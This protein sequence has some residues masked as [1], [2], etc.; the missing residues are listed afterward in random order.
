[1]SDA[2]QVRFWGVRGSIPCPGLS[3]ATYGGN[4]ACVE[5]R[6]GDTVL[7]LDAGTGLRPLGQALRAEG[8]TTLHLLLSHVHLDHV[9]GLP[10]FEPAYDPHTRLVIRA[11]NLLPEARL[12]QTLERLLSV[13]FFP[14]SPDVFR[15]AVDCVDFRAGEAFQL[16]G[17]VHVT[18]APLNHP[19]RAT[20][21]RI[22][23]QG[24]S[25][26]Y[27]TDTE[28]PASGLDA[29]ILNLI[30]GT[31]L[32]IYDSTYN[33]ATYPAHKGWGHSTWEAG[34]ALAQAGEVRGFALFHHDPDADDAALA[35]VEQQ[36]QAT[37]AGAFAAREGMTV[38]V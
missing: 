17:A 36:A 31:D 23:W 11:G 37:F 21:Y 18:T 12:R 9:I 32:L 2:F 16:P 38:R 26:C 19:D 15:A 1:M 4:T 3:H 6:C 10:F 28:H 34:V 13:P 8:V 22:Q 30:Q 25:V 5:V 14:V 7:I 24:R 27:V 33:T 29:R 20:G 35:I